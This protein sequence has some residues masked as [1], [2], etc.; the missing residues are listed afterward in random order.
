MICEYYLTTV[1]QVDRC[2]SNSFKRPSRNLRIDQDNYTATIWQE[3]QALGWRSAILTIREPMLTRVRVY[4]SIVSSVV[5]FEFHLTE[6]FSV[7]RYC[8]A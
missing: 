2:E 4:Q 1:E 7:W 5:D 8:L 6:E 3:F